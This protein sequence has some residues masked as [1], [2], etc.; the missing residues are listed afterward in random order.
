ML[1]RSRLITSVAAINALTTME[2]EVTEY[3]LRNKEEDSLIE[4]YGNQ[5]KSIQELRKDWFMGRSFGHDVIFHLNP[6]SSVFDAGL[7]RQLLRESKR[8]NCFK[9]VITFT[10]LGFFL[11]K[12][13]ILLSGL[14][15]GRNLLI[16]FDVE[17]PTLKFL[18]YLEVGKASRL[19]ALL[20][21]IA[22]FF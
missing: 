16:N 5:G 6:K 11:P 2:A 15:L 3:F 21:P 4:S 10:F 9:D 19:L 8:E 14:N 17:D 18:E 7:R 1:L 13:T 12:T 20:M 22:T